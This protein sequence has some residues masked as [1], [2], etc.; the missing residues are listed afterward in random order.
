MVLDT[1][2]KQKSFVITSIIM[3]L[4]V[5][6]LLLAK[7]TTS[8]TLP[9]DEEGGIA[10]T[11]GTDNKG[12]G[13]INP[14]KSVEPAVSHSQPTERPQEVEN[15]PERQPSEQVLAQD[16]DAESVVIPKK[17][18]KKPKRETP[19]PEKTTPK[20]TEQR[21]S[22]STT[23]ALSSV[24]NSSVKNPRT[25][26]GNGNQGDDGVAGYKGDPKGDPYSNSFYGGNGEGSGGGAGKGWGLNGRKYISGK[27]M[28]QE[29]NE[30]GFVIVRIEVDRTG[31]VVR[32]KAGEKGT[33]NNAPCLLE[34]AQKSALTYRFNSDEKAPQTQIGFLAINFKLGEGK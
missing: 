20:K 9:P 30:S 34:A 13:A 12:M 27:N 2:Y 22:S 3:G 17:E 4:V 24:L 31:K 11:F 1:V 29:C 5:L 33:T 10:I 25:G 28:K 32:A 6:L 8:N 15:T 21:P 14:P 7:M 19:K 26:T 16:T 23:D 18:N